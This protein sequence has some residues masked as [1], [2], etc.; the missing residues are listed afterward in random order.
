MSVVSQACL[1]L[2]FTAHIAPPEEAQATGHRAR[3][4]H[5][6]LPVGSRTDKT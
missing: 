1:C 4:S 6:Q 3:P 2:E 5:T